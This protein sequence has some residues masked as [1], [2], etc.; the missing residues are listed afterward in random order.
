MHTGLSLIFQNLDEVDDRDV[1]SAELDLALRAEETGFD[2]VWVPEHHFTN[3]ELTPDVPQLL[4]WLAGQTTRIKLGTDVTVLPWHDPVRVAEKFSLLDHL[5]GGRALLGIGRGLGPLE[6]DGFRVDMNQSTELFAE[7][8]EAIV[9]ALENGYI[10]YDGDVYK[11]P[12]VD[13]RP[14][15]F[16]SFKNRTFASA[17]SPS[18]VALMARLGI[19][20]AVIPQKPW[21]RIETE[22]ADYRERYAELNGE[23]PPKPFLGIFVAVHEDPAVAQR[24]R[25][26]YLQRYA[27]SSVVHYE[28]DNPAFGEIRGYEYYGALAKNIEREGVEKFN[29]VLADFQ[30][31]GTPDQVVEQLLGM[32]DRTHAGA[33]V[34]FLSYGGMSADVARANYDLFAAEVLPA[35]KSKD[36]GGDF[37]VLDDSPEG[38]RPAAAHV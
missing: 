13:I 22:L 32:V 34:A 9:N 11:Q 7:Y 17:I 27:R 35:L 31:W 29:N 23:P 24:M 26:T 1:Y 8:T 5:S 21:D 15:P 38:L 19:G 25:E 37:G 20:L 33:L 2:S 18:S 4:S 28:F 3:Y 16:K 14:R 10:E 30:V 36:V 6:F 12:R